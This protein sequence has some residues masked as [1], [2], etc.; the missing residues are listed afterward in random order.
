MKKSNPF[1]S[2]LHSQF[3]I[4]PNPD[5]ALASGFALVWDNFELMPND[6]R[7][8]CSKIRQTVAIAE[9]KRRL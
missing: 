8:E 4:P 1:F 2:I 3:F 5:A 7:A 9:I 6:W